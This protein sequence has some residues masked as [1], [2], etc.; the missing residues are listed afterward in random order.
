M[1]CDVS[2]HAENNNHTHTQHAI[3]QQIPTRAIA[4]VALI[5]APS[6]ALTETTELTCQ[7]LVMKKVDPMIKAKSTNPAV[8]M[9]RSMNGTRNK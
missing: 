5:S 3:A 7:T 6:S 4:T 1:V 2:S 9:F 8:Q